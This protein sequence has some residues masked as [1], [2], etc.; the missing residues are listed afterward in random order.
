MLETHDRAAEIANRTTH[1][2]IHK[3]TQ[4]IVITAVVTFTSGHAP[5]DSDW[6]LP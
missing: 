4:T 5:L 2:D 6:L 1:A 3:L